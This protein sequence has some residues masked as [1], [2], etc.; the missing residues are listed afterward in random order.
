VEVFCSDGLIWLDDDFHGPLHVQTTT[1]TDIR[2]CPS[3]A[4][5]DDLPLAHDEVGL[6]LRLYVEADRAFVDAVVSGAQ[7]APGLAEALVAHRLV[8]AAYRSAEAGGRPLAFDPP[9]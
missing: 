2:L 4:W 3:P 5:V 9:G 8:D 1:G 6:A 7:P